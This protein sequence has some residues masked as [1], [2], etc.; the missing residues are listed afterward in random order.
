MQCEKCISNSGVSNTRRTCED[1]WEY[2]ING[3]TDLAL[4]AI[5]VRERYC[6]TCNNEYITYELTEGTLRELVS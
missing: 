2:K 5:V 3:D 1:G 4:Y 6:K